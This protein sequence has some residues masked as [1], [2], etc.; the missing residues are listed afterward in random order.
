MWFAEKEKDRDLAMMAELSNSKR[1]AK[2]FRVSQKDENTMTRLLG[3][4]GGMVV[5]GCEA[6]NKTE[7]IENK[8]KSL[9]KLS[10][11]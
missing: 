9:K 2:E 1:L 6:Q 11:L 4:I 3:T 10:I 8:P 7:Q 5:T